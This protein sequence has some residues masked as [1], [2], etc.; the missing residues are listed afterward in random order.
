MRCFSW[1]VAVCTAVEAVR[2]GVSE[3]GWRTVAVRRNRITQG[4]LR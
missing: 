2:P 4:V 1:P 3:E